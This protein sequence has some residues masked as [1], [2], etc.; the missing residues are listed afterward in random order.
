PIFLQRRPRQ[1]VRASDRA[2]VLL[3]LELSRGDQEAGA[4]RGQPPKAPAPGPARGRSGGAAG[5]QR[6]ERSTGASTAVGSQRARAR[7]PGTP[8]GLALPLAVVLPWM[9]GGGRRP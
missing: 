6:G 7:G 2:A 4:G 9:A 3:H 1:P 5:P 8:A